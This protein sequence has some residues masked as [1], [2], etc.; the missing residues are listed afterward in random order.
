MTFIQDGSCNASQV[1]EDLLLLHAADWALQQLAFSELCTLHFAFDLPAF[2]DH[3]D[4]WYSCSLNGKGECIKRVCWCFD[5]M[6]VHEEYAFPYLNAK[7]KYADELRLGKEWTEV[8]CCVRWRR[9]QLL[10]TTKL[11]GYSCPETSDF[12]GAACGCLNS[13]DTPY[14]PPFPFLPITTQFLLHGVRSARTE[15]VHDDLWKR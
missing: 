3:N 12:E 5:R 10:Q 1:W 6:T 8:T 13:S 11:Q 9:P 14:L 7:G 15:E 4:C 2:E